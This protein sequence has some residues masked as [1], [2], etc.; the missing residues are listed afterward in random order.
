MERWSDDRA[1]K[2]EEAIVVVNPQERIE[3]RES[4]STREFRSGQSYTVEAALKSQPDEAV[5]QPVNP[6]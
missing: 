6:R 5:S 3:Y 4:I 2:N 1:F